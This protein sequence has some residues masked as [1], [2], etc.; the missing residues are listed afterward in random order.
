M[1][2]LLEATRIPDDDS[3]SIPIAEYKLSHARY[4]CTDFLI[5]TSEEQ[6]RRSI[7]LER[8]A[9]VAGPISRST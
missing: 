4:F 7:P 8:E 2:F 5:A 3:G 9:D 1:V 6:F